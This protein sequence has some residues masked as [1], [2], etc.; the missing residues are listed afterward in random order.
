MEAKLKV[1]GMHC[2]SCPLLIDEELEELPGVSEAKTSLAKQETHVVFD[3]S[4]VELPELLE[5]IEELG[6]RAAPSD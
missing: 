6:Y 2:A 5:T 4:Q 3:E 1:E